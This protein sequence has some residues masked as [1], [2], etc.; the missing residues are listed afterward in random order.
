MNSLPAVRH[1]AL[2]PCRGEASPALHLHF[3]QPLKPHHQ[4]I[5]LG[6]LA[7]YILQNEGGE[8]FE[9]D[10]GDDVV[11]LQPAARHGRLT[12]LRYVALLRHLGLELT[13]DLPFIGHGQC[14][15]DNENHDGEVRHV[16]TIPPAMH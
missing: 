15:A 9:P 6:D 14:P 4:A 10:F 2:L 5:I 13:G 8:T 1:V 16:P 3:E 7:T 11:S 12:E